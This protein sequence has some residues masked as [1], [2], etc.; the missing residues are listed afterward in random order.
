MKQL[1]LEILYRLSHDNVVF[2]MKGAIS[3][4]LFGVEPVELEVHNVLDA[5]L[6][7]GG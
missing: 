1:R 2:I 4:I 6:H 7:Q 3:V 5:Y